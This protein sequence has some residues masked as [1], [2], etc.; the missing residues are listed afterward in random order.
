MALTYLAGV[1]S[2]G[3]ALVAGLLAQAGIA[4]AVIDDLSGS[5]ANT[6][7]FA[8]SGLALI[9]AAIWAPEGLTGLVRAGVS[10]LG[11]V[12]STPADGPPPP[13]AVAANDEVAP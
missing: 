3:G 10:R 9:A 12:A 5:E 6:Y 1:S 8:I 7:V 2:V 4:V 11:R 13:V